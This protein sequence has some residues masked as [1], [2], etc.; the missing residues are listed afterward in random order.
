MSF[1][2]FGREGEVIASAPDIAD[3]QDPARARAQLRAAGFSHLAT[4]SAELL[5][6]RRM[7][8]YMDPKER[9]L[10]ERFFTHCYSTEAYD[11]DLPP[12]VPPTAA[13]ARRL[14]V[15]DDIQVWQ[16][17]RSTTHECLLVGLVHTNSSSR[18][19][20]IAQWSDNDSDVLTDVRTLRKRARRTDGKSIIG[21]LTADGGDT[22]I[23]ILAV[24][25]FGTFVGIMLAFSWWGVLLVAGGVMG[26]VAMLC[27]IGEAESAAGWIGLTALVSMAAGL[28]GVAIAGFT[29]S[30][31]DVAVCQ[32]YQSYD[33][34][35]IRTPTTGYDLR[36]GWYFGKH[37]PDSE[38]AAKV[39][40][41]YVGHTIRVTANS[42]GDPDITKVTT[43]KTVQP[44]CGA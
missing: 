27:L 8:T 19:F 1:K 17:P 42:L 35:K 12:E 37:Y 10:W 34:W 22:L 3:A 21:K 6:A 23:A 25:G 2:P 14:E 11:G 33:A 18:A 28:L 20:K 15:F 26:V 31:K 41:P 7:Y 5:T 36:P 16:D 40:M 29:Q 32:V 9:E 24:I 13:T 43:A 38:S 30:T 4:R 44:G 39:L